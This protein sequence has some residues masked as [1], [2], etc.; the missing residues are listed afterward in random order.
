MNTVRNPE[1]FCNSGSFTLGINSP[2]VTVSPVAT[3]QTVSSERSESPLTVSS[4]TPSPAKAGLE[5]PETTRIWGLDFAIL[6]TEQ[7]VQRADKI[8]ENR[9]CRF[10]V[11]ANLNYLMLSDKRRSMTAV[12]EAADA[13]IADGNPIVYRS[14]LSATPLPCRVAG[15]DLI[16]ELARLA[17][18]RGYRIYFLGAAPGVAQKASDKLM[19]MFP[20]L[21]IAGCDSPPFRTLSEAE[22][23]EMRQKIRQSQADILLVAFGQPKG[24]QWIFENHELLNVPLSIQLGASFDFLAGTAKR[25]PEFWQKIGCEWLYR[26]LREP[27]RLAPRYLQNIAFLAQC[28]LRDLKELFS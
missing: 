12:N 26:T 9:D 25:A 28:I 18:D 23:E 5:P 13:I 24:E 6:D 1:P 16:V 10:F 21:Q 27:R 8:I 20:K 2:T 4:L 22:S 3:S 7:V 11:T 17:S 19:E 14:R 15:S